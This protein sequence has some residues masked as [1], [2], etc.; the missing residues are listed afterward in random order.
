MPAPADPYTPASPSL[1]FDRKSPKFHEFSH[2]I[3]IAMKRIWVASLMLAGLVGLTAVPALA[4]P[5]VTPPLVATT[6]NAPGDSPIV[7]VQRPHDWR[8]SQNNQRNNRLNQRNRHSW[9]WSQR[10]RR[11]RWICWHNRW[12]R[13][14]CR[15]RYY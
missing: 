1:R 13:R 14:Q 8:W 11:Y 5:G 12:S 15:R 7:Q 2:S 4:L 9:R 10:A 3:G 6:L